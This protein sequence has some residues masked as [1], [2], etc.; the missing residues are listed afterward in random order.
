[1]FA[2]LAGAVLVGRLILELF[3]IFFHAGGVRDAV[4]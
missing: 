4:G 3:G 1:V 2:I